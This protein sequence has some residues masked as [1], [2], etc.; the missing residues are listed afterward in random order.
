MPGAAPK[1]L[2]DAKIW[3]AAPGLAW[4]LLALIAVWWLRAELKTLASAVV[5]RLKE[6]SP[7]K[8]G[9]LEFGAA[10]DAENL[11]PL[12]H[13]LTQRVLALEARAAGAPSEDVGNLP[14]LIDLTSHDTEA[15]SAEQTPARGPTT[16]PP[17][18]P[19]A[20]RVAQ[21]YHLAWL[22]DRQQQTGPY[23]G[24]PWAGFAGDRTGPPESTG[25]RRLKAKVD[26]VPDRPGL[27]AVELA[28]VSEDDSPIDGP[29]GFLLHPTFPQPRRV[30]HPESGRVRVR[31]IAWGAFTVGCIDDHGAHLEI[32]LAKLPDAPEAFR[33]R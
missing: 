10:A 33:N 9:G 15:V 31:L 19:S 7:L 21:S 30:V 28:V 5:V 4:A 13:E 16:P 24:D 14:E 1:P 29:I 23:A 25:A 20:S 2:Y 6:G 3:E 12:I 8:L 11:K 18:S 17:R 27:F 22:L 26:V 32:N